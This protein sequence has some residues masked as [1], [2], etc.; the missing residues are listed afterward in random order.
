MLAVAGEQLVCALPGESHGDVPRRELGQAR[1]SRARRGRRAARPC[2]STGPRGRLGRR[3]T[4]RARG[5]RC[6]GRS[7]TCRASASSFVSPA[8]A[9]PTAKVLT[10]SLMCRAI[11]ATIRL[12]S[13]PPESIAPSGTSLISRS[14]TDSSSLAR[15]RSAC[16][17]IVGPGSGAGAGYDQNARSDTVPSSDDERV[18][19]KQLSHAAQ[20]RERRREEAEREIRVDRRVVELEVD[21]PRCEHALELGGEHEPIS[22]RRIVERLDPEPVA[23][24]DGATAS[25]V[26]DGDP[27]HPAELLRERVAVGLVEMRDDL[28]VAAAGEAVAVG[29]ELVAERSRAR[30]A[31]RSAPPR[32]CRPRSGTADARPRRRRCSGGGRRS[33]SPGRHRFRRRPARDAG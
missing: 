6:R 24:E 31:R 19:R 32:R 26:P 25:V 5:G 33:R 2:A 17:S 12:E 29:A 16:S 30:R 9:K 3:A 4:A 20:R 18:A 23:R 11:K 22:G 1:G 7:T 13:S 28:G 27:E 8:P 14:R 15:S 21:E 10:G